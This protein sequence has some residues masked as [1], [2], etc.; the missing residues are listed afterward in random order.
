MLIR[1]LKY[2]LAGLVNRHPYFW[3]IAWKIMPHVTCLLPHEK[4]YY[5]FK[6]L[7]LDKDGLF[8]DVGANNGLS[9]LGFRHINNHY[10]IFSV[11]ANRYHEPSL[12]KL[13][14]K[15]MK[16]D[17][18]IAGAG[19]ENS[20]ITLYTAIY[21]GVALHTGA[22]VDLAYLKK[23]LERDFSKHVIEH[24]TYTQQVV[25][26]IRLDDL[27]LAPDIIKIDAEGFDYQV[28]LG[29]KTTITSYRPYVLA[30]Y[31]PPLQ[32]ELETFCLQISYSLFV[33]ENY[34]NLFVPFDGQRE[35]QTYLG[36]GT[37]VN[38]FL[39]PSEKVKDL[40]VGMV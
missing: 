34:R 4:S 29:L 2:F 8:L 25:N 28:L 9:A 7:A 16:F 6:H 13:K 39:I 30:E 22:S 32:E 23:A 26:V 10:R 21:K 40:P 33:F 15:I 1:R 14:K 35:L 19:N 20:Q 5:A 12:S 36:R 11:E 27:N 37:P 38:V 18:L 31:S 17:Y 24:I 3:F